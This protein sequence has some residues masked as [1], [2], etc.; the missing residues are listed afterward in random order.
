[1]SSFRALQSST[2]LLSLARFRSS[3]HASLAVS[4]PTL[5][6][7]QQHQQQRYYT[8]LTPEEEEK[9]KQRVKNLSEFAREQE[10]R[11]LNRE[12]KRLETL[13]GINTG[14]LYTWLGQYKS[15]SRDYGFMLPVW[16]AACWGA[17]FALAFVAIE[18]G[19]LDALALVAKVDAYTGWNLASHIDPTLGK[20][21]LTAMMAELM[22]PIRLPIVIVTCKPVMDYLFPGKY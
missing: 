7:S 6:P 18:V 15:L 19:G 11:Q 14:E 2:R 21:A 10:L 20:F 16:Y 8:P 13:R 17:S 22:E 1:M 12:I 5:F 3:A 9:E 4:T